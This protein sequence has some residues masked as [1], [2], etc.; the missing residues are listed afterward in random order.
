MLIYLKRIGLIKNEVYE[1]LTN[2][3]VIL[4]KQLFSFIN[5]LKNNDNNT[6]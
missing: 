5:Y 3:A 1:K 6:K 2:D 4:S